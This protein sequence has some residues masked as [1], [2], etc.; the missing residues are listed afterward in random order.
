MI[1]ARPAGQPLN[2]HEIGVH[3]ISVHEIAAEM[4]SVVSAGHAR[5]L[6][7]RARRVAG[8]GPRQELA[9]SE[10]LMVLESIASEGGRLQVLAEGLARRALTGDV[11]RPDGG[12]PR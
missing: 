6:L 9:T 8:V 5:R 12:G 11:A 10:V 2:M 1:E 4:T 7:A 3:G